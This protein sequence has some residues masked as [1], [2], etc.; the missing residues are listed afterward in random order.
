VASGAAKPPL[1]ATN[2]ITLEVHPTA[3]LITA[4]TSPALRARIRIGSSSA[5]EEL[6]PEPIVVVHLDII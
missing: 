2:A 4:P 5:L 1:W 3:R 6:H